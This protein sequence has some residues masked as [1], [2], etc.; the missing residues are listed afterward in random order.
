M[1]NK[2]YRAL[3]ST[4]CAIEN[5]KASNNTEWEAKH[6]SAR[7]A[8]MA[9]APSGSGFDSGTKLVSGGADKLVFQTAFHHMNENGMYDGWT[10]HTI[11]VLPSLLFDFSIKVSGRN[12][13]D[14]KDYI[15]DVFSSWLG[16]EINAA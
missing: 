2:V 12:R 14:I 4:S 11:T 13:N 5:C 15:T 8:L 6:L 3:A 10:E 16:M 9:G 7:K 1:A